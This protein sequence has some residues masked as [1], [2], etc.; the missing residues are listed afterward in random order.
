MTAS[1]DDNGNVIEAQRV[2]DSHGNPVD[3]DGKGTLS[4]L[5]VVF[6]RPLLRFPLCSLMYE[7]L[8]MNVCFTSMSGPFHS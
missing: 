5:L 1:Q 3:E 4:F 8:H 2:A 7:S 6:V